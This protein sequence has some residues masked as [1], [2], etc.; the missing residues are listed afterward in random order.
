MKDKSKLH[1]SQREIYGLFIIVFRDSVKPQQQVLVNPIHNRKIKNA[2][3]EQNWQADA[4]HESHLCEGDHLSQSVV[5]SEFWADVD[6]FIILL[7]NLFGFALIF[8]A[9]SVTSSPNFEIYELNQRENMWKRQLYTH[10]L[11]NGG[12]DIHVPCSIEIFIISR[13][14][15][16]LFLNRSNVVIQ[17]NDQK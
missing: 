12:A 8:G 13:E 15:K 14:E 6:V 4:V 10:S 3:Q 16:F 9:R 17:V 1:H 11:N 7:E 5:K 2:N